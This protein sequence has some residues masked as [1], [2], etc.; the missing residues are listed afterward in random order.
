MRSSA[1]KSLFQFARPERAVKGRIPVSRSC[2][3]LHS[4]PNILIIVAVN[5]IVIMIVTLIIIIFTI[6]SSREGKR[7]KRRRIPVCRSCHWQLGL[8]GRNLYT[9]STE[10]CPTN[11]KLKKWGKIEEKLRKTIVLGAQLLAHS[12]FILLAHSEYLKQA[13]LKRPNR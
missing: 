6:L 5:I 10:N 8:A 1:P 4:L 11:W 7:L 9:V 2:C 12:Y 3:H 13:W